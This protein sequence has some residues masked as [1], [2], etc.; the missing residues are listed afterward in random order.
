MDEVACNPLVS[1]VRVSPPSDSLEEHWEHR[2]AFEKLIRFSL[3]RLCGK[4]AYASLVQETETIPPSLQ[5]VLS[6]LRSFPAFREDDEQFEEIAAVLTTVFET[7]FAAKRF[8]SMHVDD[9][10]SVPGVPTDLLSSIAR[11]VIYTDRRLSQR[12]PVGHKPHFRGRRNVAAWICFSDRVAELKKRLGEPDDAVEIPLQA[13]ANGLALTGLADLLRCLTLE[14]VTAE[15]GLRE[16]L[17]GLDPNKILLAQWELDDTA[18][19]VR[20]RQKDREDDELKSGV[21]SLLMSLNGGLQ[22]ENRNYREN[23][24]RITPLGWCVAAGVVSGTLRSNLRLSL[25]S[26]TPLDEEA[27]SL[28]RSLAKFLAEPMSRM[29]NKDLPDESD[30]WKGLDSLLNDNCHK[31]SLDFAKQLEAYGRQVGLVVSEPR[32]SRRFS[33]VPSEYGDAS[34]EGRR[35]TWEV[36]LD[37]ESFQIEPW[38]IATASTASDHQGY[39]AEYRSFDKDQSESCWT[40]TR[41]KGKLISVHIAQ[42]GIA[43]LAGFAV[44][45]AENGD[46][47]HRSGIDSASDEIGENQASRPVVNSQS[48]PSTE[49]TASDASETT[50]VSI[51]IVHSD[52][53]VG[54]DALTRAKESSWENRAKVE[55]TH[56]KRIAFV[57]LQVEPY[58]SYQHPVYECSQEKLNEFSGGRWSIGKH[59]DRID[60][61]SPVER[62]R[63]RLLTEVLRA[64]ELFKV[65][66]LVLPEY[67]TRPETVNWIQRQLNYRNME[68]LVWAG[69]FRLP[70]YYDVE[71]FP[72]LQGGRDWASILPIVGGS[73]HP[74][75]DGTSGIVT[76]HKKYPSVAYNEIFDPSSSILSA[77]S[78]E[79]T[80]ITELICSEIFLAMSPTNL[81]A[82]WKSFDALF[83]RFGR[84]EVLE[85]SE[86]LYVMKDVV[87]FSRETS[88]CFDEGRIGEAAKR[89]RSIL[90]VPSMTP[91]TVD[92]AILGQANH[93]ASG[94]MTV[95]CNDSGCHSHG[96][97]CFIGEDG[98]DNEKIKE[99]RGIPG[100]GPYHG[101]TPGFFHQ[102]QADRGWL[103]TNEQAMVIADVDPTHQFGGK[104][105]PQNLLPPL[106]MVAHLPILE[107]G[108]R[109]AQ[110]DKNVVYGRLSD[111]P[112]PDLAQLVRILPWLDGLNWGNQKASDMAS[113]KFVVDRVLQG[114]SRIIS[115]PPNP[116]NTIGDDQNF[117]LARALLSLAY[118]VPENSSWLKRRAEAYKTQ[119]ASNPVPYP[120]P[121]ATD[122]LYVDLDE[123]RADD[124]EC[125]LQVPRVEIEPGQKLSD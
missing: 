54:W 16:E 59:P 52:V 82:L 19:F 93:L 34:A 75:I 18:C 9:D 31:Q 25:L 90:F 57:Q 13:L 50:R 78:H 91:R 35:R 60:V 112:A 104:P 100:A 86:E 20:K 124:D 7:R 122:W 12:L 10:P 28:F 83:Q 111:L 41:L 123:E 71:N 81:L 99:V 66:F 64:C 117:I 85:D 33:L 36:N 92:Y 72:W 88:L 27:V 69:T 110:A 119:H 61:I 121:V 62:R 3:Q 63:R 98:W 116:V 55:R 14:L 114:I 43:S 17:V 48:E 47:K 102:F 40:E 96:Q 79:S 53:P 58:G 32:W 26:A 1:I 21:A 42:P 46:K 70:P 106:E 68:T 37:V 44:L 39:K 103:G 38:R 76:R 56:Y 8:D 77:I 23:L 97:S 101:L 89:R 45:P 108:G 87:S 65:D 5:R 6:R 74:G 94:M 107:V 84:N 118:S 125:E 15:S 30:P 120:P 22:N 105:R 49:S 115:R 95:F 73:S 67:S 29:E 51:D 113:R 24:D 80:R 2:W 4:T 11:G 109:K